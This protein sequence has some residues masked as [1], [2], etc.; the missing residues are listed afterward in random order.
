MRPLSLGCRAASIVGMSH[1]LRCLE[2]GLEACTGGSER[3]VGRPQV[4]EVGFA[5][6]A[7]RRAVTDGRALR[8]CGIAGP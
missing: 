3:C 7:V 6:G 2:V 4:A 8:V 5:G 1:R